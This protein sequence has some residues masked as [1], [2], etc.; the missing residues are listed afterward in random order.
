MKT[1]LILFL[2]LFLINNNLFATCSNNKLG[3]QITVTGWTPEEAYQKLHL[4]LPKL[5]VLQT[6]DLKSVKAMMD[7][8]YSEKTALFHGIKA[9]ID[10]IATHHCKI[11][12]MFAI[13]ASIPND[14]VNYYPELIQGWLENRVANKNDFFVKYWSFESA[15]R[16]CKDQ[17]YSVLSFYYEHKFELKGAHVVD[18][19]RHGATTSYVVCGSGWHLYI[20]ADEGRKFY[21]KHDVY[22]KHTGRKYTQLYTRTD[23]LFRDWSDNMELQMLHNAMK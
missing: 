17:D 20:Y 23:G 11:N 15:K 10:M 9:N 12:N 6:V 3:R 4:E 19:F 21:K 1:K 5:G 14:A 7:N 13:T 18:E 22:F 16:F 8:N 2:L